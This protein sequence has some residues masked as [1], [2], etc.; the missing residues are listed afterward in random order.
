MGQSD[1]SEEDPTAEQRYGASNSERG[2]QM[3]A[4]IAEGT[5]RSVFRYDG[6]ADGL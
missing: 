4:E 3:E 1:E 5:R 2:S 6:T